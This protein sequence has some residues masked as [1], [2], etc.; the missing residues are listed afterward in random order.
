[1][2]AIYL[3]KS[4][5][6]TQRLLSE[7]DEMWLDTD[8]PCKVVVR[9]AG[10]VV[11]GNVQINGKRVEKPTPVYAQDRVYVGEHSFMIEVIDRA[12]D[13]KEEK[14]LA[15][16]A[17]GDD[18]ARDVYA[19]WL[20]ENGDVRRA[21]FLRVQEL[22]RTI[23]V[24]DPSFVERSRELRQ[25]AALVDLDWRIRVARTAVEGCRTSVK[26]DFVCP[27]QW[28]DL[29]ETELAEVR[30]CDLCRE[31]VFYCTT[32]AEARNHAWRGRCVAVDLTN[33]RTQG[34]LDR[35]PIAKVGMIAPR[36][37]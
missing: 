12:P 5:G 2:L 31:Q 4:G 25:L 33:E 7:K 29:V 10:C 32:V 24:S 36:R 37:P 21:E 14:L 13:A 20:E 22:L 3:C 9:P 23:E 35:P 16:I 34:D 19:D 26:F 1:V 11:E 8:P 30:F 27:K 6:V 15:D 17:A 28:S 18:E